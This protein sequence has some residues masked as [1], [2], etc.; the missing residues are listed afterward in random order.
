MG[1]KLIRLHRFDIEEVLHFGHKVF[2][3]IKQN[4]FD[5]DDNVLLEVPYFCQ[6]FHQVFVRDAQQA[7]TDWLEHFNCSLAHIVV[8]HLTMLVEDKV[9]CRSVELFVGKLRGLLSIDFLNCITN[10]VPML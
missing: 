8:Q 7:L 4:I 10:G 1:L 6:L 9:V 5:H 2:I 3:H